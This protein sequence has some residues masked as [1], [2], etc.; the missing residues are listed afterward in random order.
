MLRDPSTT[1]SVHPLR[2][3]STRR[4][5]LRRL[6]LGLIAGAEYFCLP[7]VADAGGQSGQRDAKRKHAAVAARVKQ[8]I[9]EQ[10]GV[11]MKDVLEQAHLVKDLGADSLDLVELTM[12][13]EKTFGIQVPDEDAEKL[14]TVGALI[15]YVEDHLKNSGRKQ[16]P[17]NATMSH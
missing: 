2:Q 17:K 3:C 12:A 16:H 8:V 5:F 4:I 15:T 1:A 10:L 14:C 7:G 6:T 9:V 13:L 11:D